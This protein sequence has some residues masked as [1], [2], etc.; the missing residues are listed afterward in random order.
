MKNLDLIFEGKTI[1]SIPRKDIG[2][3]VDFASITSQLVNSISHHDWALS[4]QA[5]HDVANSIH[6][7]EKY[8]V[9]A[10]Y[11]MYGYFLKQQIKKIS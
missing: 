3:D 11:S 7:K 1:H 10:A 9:E 6:F 8:M 4:I 2:V 5:E